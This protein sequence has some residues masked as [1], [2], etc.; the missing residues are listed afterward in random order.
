MYDDNQ[1]HLFRVTRTP[2]TAK[3]NVFSWQRKPRIRYGGTQM[4]V[5]TYVYAGFDNPRK[6]DVKVELLEVNVL[7]EVDMDKYRNRNKIETFLK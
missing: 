7:G 3:S 5:Q 2:V 4:A 1:R 6:Y